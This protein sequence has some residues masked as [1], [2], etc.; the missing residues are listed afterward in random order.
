[1][2]PPARAFLTLLLL[3]LGILADDH[4]AA[5]AFDDLALLA[6]LFHRRSDFHRKNHVLSDSRAAL[7]RGWR[8]F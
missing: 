5:L 2:Q 7:W 6:D 8:P 1:M 3:V 4:D